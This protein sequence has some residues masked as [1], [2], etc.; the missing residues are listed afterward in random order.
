MIFDWREAWACFG[1]ALYFLFVAAVIVTVITLATANA[2]DVGQWEA[3]DPIIRQWY[4]T[5]MQPDNPGISCCGEADAYWADQVE[6]KDG[7]VFAI[8]T[9]TRPD[10]P[11]GR[12]HVPPGTRVEVPPHKMTW[13]YGNPT[14]HVIV[15]LG[16]GNSVLCYVQGGGV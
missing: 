6:V 8:I 4:K 12:R 15:F 16:A 11:L 5:L 9:D 10:A 13:K 7:K 3:A 2:R 14:G 1:R